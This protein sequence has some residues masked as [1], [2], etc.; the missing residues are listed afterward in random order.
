MGLAVL[1]FSYDFVAMFKGSGLQSRWSK[2]LHALFTTSN[3]KFGIEPKIQAKQ[4]LVQKFGAPKLN[5]DLETVI[6]IL[7]G[8]IP[9]ITTI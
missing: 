2:K 9:N 3:G 7:F 5:D 1:A 4:T 6:V 8:C